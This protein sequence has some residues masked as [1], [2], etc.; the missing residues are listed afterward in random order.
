MTAEPLS[1]DFKHQKAVYDGRS[2]RKIA[3]QS[4]QPSSC[5][6]LTEADDFSFR[7]TYSLLKSHDDRPS[8][9]RTEDLLST[10]SDG[11]FINGADGLCELLRVDT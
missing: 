10:A 7:D 6:L 3:N 5:L 4:S 9:A 8:S 2:S 1:T 11:L